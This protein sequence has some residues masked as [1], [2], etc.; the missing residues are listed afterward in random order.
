MRVFACFTLQVTNKEITICIF[1][2]G[3]DDVIKQSLDP[4]PLFHWN[5]FPSKTVMSY[6]GWRF[7]LVGDLGCSS[8]SQK[9]IS[10]KQQV[11][12]KAIFWSFR[13]LLK[14]CF[15]ENQKFGIFSKLLNA[16]VHILAYWKDLCFPHP[17]MS[18]IDFLAQSVRE[19]WPI[20]SKS[21]HSGF[22][23]P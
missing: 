9:N 22:C 6:F 20:T 1:F 2:S 11:S 14:N 16:K 10:T 5:S 7:W 21:H 12:V 13:K 15:L 19:L 3:L 18:Y 17:R 4:Y 23:K 8:P